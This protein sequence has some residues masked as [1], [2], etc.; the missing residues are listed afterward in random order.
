MGKKESAPITI[1]LMTMD[2]YPPVK[3]L[4]DAEPG[5]T[6]TSVDSADRIAMLLRRCPGI[7]HV[8]VMEGRIVGSVLGSEDT[9]RGYVHHLV[10]RADLRGKGLGKKLMDAVEGAFK[11]VGIP[12]IHLFVMRTNPV[13]VE[14]YKRL[15]WHVR[16]D[17]T[18][19]SKNL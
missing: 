8:A 6:I 1:R 5:L 18:M 10:V 17:L 7:S 11:S 9:R 2:D 12:K 13:V 15:G 4:W 3:A 19:M 16:E 14:F